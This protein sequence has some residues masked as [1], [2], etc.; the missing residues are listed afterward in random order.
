LQLND[1]GV[2]SLTSPHELSR[3]VIAAAP[4]S[5]PAWHERN[6]WTLTLC[7]VVVASLYLTEFKLWTL[8]DESSLRASKQFAM[9][10]YPPAHSAD[11]LALVARG[12]WTTIAVA[13][14]GVT[15][16]FIAALPLA[17]LGAR[18]LSISRL[19]TG[20]VAFLPAALR[21]LVRWLLIVLRSVPE[22]VWGLVFVRAIGLGDT[23]GVMAIA[24]TFTG[25][26]GKVF[27]EIFESQE[28]RAT[29][30]LL[31]NG[32]GRVQAFLYGTLPACI[33]EMVSYTVFRWECAIRSSVILGFVG[34]GGLGQQMELSS[35]M[36]AGD[37]VITMLAVFVF[38]VWMA[39]VMSKR[40]RAWLD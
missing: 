18:T 2:G 8:L 39:D 17:L 20:R 36:L 13:T 11:F 7:A 9:S 15:L 25:M 12:A 27:L 24:L 33:S 4:T 6:L 19:G 22:L 28:T 38:L 3:R 14:A 16:A 40:L 37:E 5:D 26:M 21:T 1:L 10:F 35:R 32:A 31:N 30:A 23:A 29:E 34:A